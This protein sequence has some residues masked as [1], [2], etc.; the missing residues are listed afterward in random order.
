MN[1]IIWVLLISLSRATTHLIV[2]NAN[3][4]KYWYKNALLNSTPLKID[5]FCIY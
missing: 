3:L 2:D 4:S 5:S 1:K